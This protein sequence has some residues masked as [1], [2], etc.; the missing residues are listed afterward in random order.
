ME[1]QKCMN[2]AMEYIEKNLSGEIDYCTAAQFLNCSD[3]EF[4]R[5]FSFMTQMPLSEYIRRR[6]LTLAASDIRSGEKI[7]EVALRYGYASQAAFSR[8]FHQWHGVTPAAARKEGTVLKVYPK[9][10]FKQILREESRMKQTGGQR[11]N[12]I[13]A[14]EVGDAISVSMDCDDIYHTNQFFWDTKGSDILGAIS[15]PLYGAYVSEEKCRLLDDVSGK[16]VL[17]IGCGAGDSL[18]YM[19]VH[20]AAELWGLDLSKE[21]LLK[22]GIN[23]GEKSLSAELVCAPMEEESGIPKEYFDIVY[24][25]YGIG[26]TTDLETTF[27]RIFSYLK[28]D[29]VFIFSWS[30]PIQKCVASEE[31]EFLFKKCYF[32]E[33]WYSVAVEGGVLSLSDRK[34]STYINALAKVGFVVE[35]M[36][37]ESEE[38]ILKEKTDDFA[39]KAEMLPVTFVIKA[40][41]K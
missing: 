1:W 16:K 30:H 23:L 26:W 11:T 6:R 25:I 4:R 22:A 21:Q 31:G 2:Q 29:G 7:V 9:L 32:D 33:S 10:I 13:G 38:E 3:W 34:M 5:I 35:Q 28:R 19:G 41:K 36:V 12:I 39:K 17:E 14:A 24:S 15:L 20:G 8:A 27:Q 40:R 37:E 18:A